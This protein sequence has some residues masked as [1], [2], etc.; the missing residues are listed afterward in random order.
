M[1]ISQSLLKLLSGNH[2]SIFS[3]S[4]LDLDPSDPKNN[5]NLPF[6]I[7]FLYTKFHVDISFLTKVIVQK[8][9]KLTP[10]PPARPTTSPSQKSIW[11]AIYNCCTWWNIHVFQ[12]LDLTPHACTFQVLFP[13]T[14]AYRYVTVIT[15]SVTTFLPHMI[16]HIWNVLKATSQNSCPYAWNMN[17]IKV[18][19]AIFT[20]KYLTFIT[21]FSRKGET[22]QF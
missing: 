19:T 4:D 9:Q 8:R 3:N 11:K 16:C 15:P 7:R 6:L 5:P 12:S 14:F 17:S 1:I 20:R 13:I 22:H 18:N 2:F 10:K 21:T